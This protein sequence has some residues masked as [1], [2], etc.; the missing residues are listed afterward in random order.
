M[1]LIFKIY[2]KKKIANQNQNHKNHKKTKKVIVIKKQKRELWM[3]E[4]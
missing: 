3:I 4:I 1:S 2:S